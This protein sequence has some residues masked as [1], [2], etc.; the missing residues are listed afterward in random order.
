MELSEQDIQIINGLKAGDESTYNQL[1][2][3]Y[4]IIL[5]VFAAKYV[6]DLETAREIVQDLFV[7]FFEI[8]STLLITSSV[9]SYLY[10]S[11]RNRCLNQIRHTKL[12][13]KH[14]EN[15]KLE[16]VSGYNLE[17]LIM[18]TE[19]EHQIFKIV[20]HM[21]DQCRKIFQM[22]RVD[23][24]RNKEIALLLNISIRTV[25]TQISKALKILRNS[26][27]DQINS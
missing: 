12:H 15:L 17:D 27:Q 3:K 18:E 9:E 6:K 2:N 10:Q 1:F 8:R 26:L 5:C 25:E 7:H 4:Y 14:L 16:E 24:K 22:S 19:L 11:L 23:G 21:P 20:S 13:E